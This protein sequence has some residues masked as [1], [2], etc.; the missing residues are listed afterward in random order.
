[1]ISNEIPVGPEIITKL[2][3][4]ASKYHTLYKGSAGEDNQPQ[5]CP[6]FGRIRNMTRLQ[7]ILALFS[8]DHEIF[9]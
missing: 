6:A 1:M 9:V 7:K 5:E 2:A 8:D 4:E 3:K